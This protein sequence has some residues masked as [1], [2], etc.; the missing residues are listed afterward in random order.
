MKWAP[1]SQLQ[2][3]SEGWTTEGSKI[4]AMGLDCEK[5]VFRKVGIPK[6]RYSV[7][8]HLRNLFWK[9]AESLNAVAFGN[10]TGFGLVVRKPVEVG[11]FPK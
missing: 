2:D 10:E 6:S 8:C 7:L 9:N 4:A 1:S 5:S 11:R 3:G